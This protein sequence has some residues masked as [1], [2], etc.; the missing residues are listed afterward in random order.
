[1]IKSSTIFLH[2]FHHLDSINP[3]IPFFNTFTYLSLFQLTYLISHSNLPLQFSFKQ[4]YEAQ[5]H[6]LYLL[7]TSTLQFS[8][9]QARETQLHLSL[10]SLT[11]CDGLFF[12]IGGSGSISIVKYKC[13]FF[14]SFFKELFKWFF[15]LFSALHNIQIHLTCDAWV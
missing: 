12:E 9:K 3:P 1:M 7:T 4:V 13:S 2:L 8:F 14:L 15:I 5:L 10:I 11:I 6:L